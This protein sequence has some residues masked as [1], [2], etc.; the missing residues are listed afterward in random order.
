[1]KNQKGFTLIELM[2]VVAIIGILAA[3]AIPQ[4]QNYVARSEA[5]TGLATISPLKTAYEELILRGETTGIALPAS[6]SLSTDTDNVLGA[7]QLVAL[8]TGVVSSDYSDGCAADACYIRFVFSADA[9]AS[10]SPAV[11]GATI[12]LDRDLNGTWT[13]E[14]TPVAANGGTDNHAP[15]GCD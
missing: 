10:V 2:I 11:K 6:V 13:C 4:Y 14:Y 12:Q 3:V 9:T 7:P 8:T 15:K 5:S 1:M